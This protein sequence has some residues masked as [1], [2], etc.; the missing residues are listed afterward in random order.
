MERYLRECYNLMVE[1]IKSSKSIKPRTKFKLLNLDPCQE[2][3]LWDII[4]RKGDS[5]EVDCFIRVC[6]SDECLKEVISYISK[7][8]NW[9]YSLFCDILFS[10]IIKDREILETVLDIS[11]R[12]SI[13]VLFYTQPLPK[14]LIKKNLSKIDK[15]LKI[16]ILKTGQLSLDDIGEVDLTE[17]EKDVIDYWNLSDDEKWKYIESVIDL[18]G[19]N[20][21]IDRGRRKIIMTVE[22][23]Y[24]N[25]FYMS[26]PTTT[27]DHT[28][29]GT[30]KERPIFRT[31]FEVDYRII[32]KNGLV[33]PSNNE[34]Y[35]KI[36]ENTFYGKIFRRGIARH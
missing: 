30:L 18:R 36:I 28:Y 16:E 2:K 21:E 7:R 8:S 25:V 20:A 3:E 32:N 9:P 5:N 27:I 11:L 4:Q 26:L 29:F 33:V 22:D 23:Y 6:Q 24:D 10:R 35:Y 13:S 17:D 15:Y 14:D 12:E 31:K 34:N 19:D 1:D